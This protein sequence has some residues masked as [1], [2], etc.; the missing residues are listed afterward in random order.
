M[1]IIVRISP[2]GDLAISV[3]G[4]AGP[5]CQEK[6]RRLERALGLVS[7]DTKTAEYNE[8]AHVSQA[9]TQDA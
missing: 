2:A 9:R 4:L 3:K 8:E 5:G 1:K 7:A 6:T